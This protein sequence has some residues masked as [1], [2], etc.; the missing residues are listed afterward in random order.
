MRKRKKMPEIIKQLYPKAEKHQQ[1][2]P[3]QKWNLKHKHIELSWKIAT[4]S[5]DF[6]LCASDVEELSGRDVEEI[7]D[8]ETALDPDTLS[9]TTE[10][11]GDWGRT[12]AIVL[13]VVFDPEGLL[14]SCFWVIESVSCYIRRKKVLFY[15]LN[16]IWNKLFQNFGWD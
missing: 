2:P 13:E 10:T 6:E 1:N 9:A 11:A 8:L 3:I 5:D 15:I 4:F 16:F 7:E 12:E 14:L